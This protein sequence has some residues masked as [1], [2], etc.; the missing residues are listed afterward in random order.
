MIS[1]NDNFLADIDLANCSQVPLSKLR[2]E[3]Q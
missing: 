3:M 1:G 2:V